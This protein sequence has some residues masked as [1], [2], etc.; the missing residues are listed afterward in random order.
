[1][2][3]HA[4]A[5]RLAKAHLKCNKPMRA[6]AGDKHK[7]VVKSCYDGEEKIVRYG[8]RDYEDYRQH[9]DPERRK[10]F[11]A[12]MRCDEKMDKNTPRYWACSRL[13]A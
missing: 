11:R 1:M 5:K 13:W 7:F 4:K 8:H 9:K 10:N 12:R 2:A 6:P 3:D